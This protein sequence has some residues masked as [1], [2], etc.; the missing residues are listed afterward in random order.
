MSCKLNTERQ[1]IV[2]A[3]LWWARYIP[4]FDVRPFMKEYGICTQLEKVD[5]LENAHLDNEAFYRTI[6]NLGKKASKKASKAKKTSEDEEDPSIP[7]EQAK[8]FV[9]A[10]IHELDVQKSYDGIK[11][12]NSDYDPPQEIFSAVELADIDIQPMLVFP[13]KVNMT[14]RQTGQVF[15]GYKEIYCP[16][17]IHKLCTGDLKDLPCKTGVIRSPPF[18]VLEIDEQHFPNLLAKYTQYGREKIDHTYQIEDAVDG[19]LFF[20]FRSKDVAGG[21]EFLRTATD[22]ELLEILTCREKMTDLYIGTSA[23]YDTK[24]PTLN[25]YKSTFDP[26]YF[27]DMAIV[28]IKDS[29]YQYVTGEI[30]LYENAFDN[31][32]LSTDRTSEN[33]IQNGLLFSSADNLHFVPLDVFEGYYFE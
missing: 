14:I 19:K 10:L 16:D 31:A 11:N 27:P 17:G 24:L 26:I 4:G 1:G 29:L 25:H 9:D 33:V 30:K 32:I 6:L 8:A 7:F 20:S 13:F 18:R 3:V 28:H 12:L 2:A 21:E 15:L 23:Y 5:V 22:E